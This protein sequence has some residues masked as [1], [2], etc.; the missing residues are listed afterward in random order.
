MRKLPENL[1]QGK[2]GEY[3][4]AA[5]LLLR[6][7]NPFFPAVDI[8][9]DLILD[10]GIKI[11]V[12]SAHLRFQKGMYPQGAYWFKLTVRCMMSNGKMT[13]RE[14]VFSQECDFVVLWGIEQN[15]FWIV[16]AAHLDGHQLVVVGA[17]VSWIDTDLEALRA[18]KESGKTYREIA[19][20]NGIN[21]ATAYNTI[22]GKRE[23]S[24]RTQMIKAIRG[25]E[26]RWDLIDE[27]L[28]TIA[29]SD[30]ALPGVEETVSVLSE[31]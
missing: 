8:G 9:A 24:G 10:S 22:A 2:A 3:T 25:C 26:G 12:K 19:K 28:A 23:A 20:E 5:Q 4:V 13:K 17:D 11:Q 31:T 21:L 30:G 27:M 7:H 16:P 18:A 29:V 6:G 1:A 14:R 15:R